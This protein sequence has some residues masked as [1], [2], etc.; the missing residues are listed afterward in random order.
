MK[1]IVQATLERS[2]SQT[3]LRSFALILIAE[4]ITI[5]VAWRLLDIN[6]N[7][8]IQQKTQQTVSIAQQVAASSDWSQID[9]IRMGKP[10]ALFK[11]YQDRLSDLD[12]RYFPRK[13]GS[14]YIAG[15]KNGEEYDIGASSVTPWEKEDKANRW[16]LDA[17]AQRKTTY[18]P[19]L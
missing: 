13:E 14:V 18:S 7:H 4:A 16:E 5:L 10:S 15:V 11:K 1:S 12:N 9:Q 17:Y 6:A 19:S 8:W 3:F 2:R